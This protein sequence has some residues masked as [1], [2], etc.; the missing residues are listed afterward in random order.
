[1]YS[2]EWGQVLDNLIILFLF[3]GGALVTLCVIDWALSWTL[4]KPEELPHD[5]PWES[6]PPKWSSEFGWATMQWCPVCQVP[7]HLYGQCPVRIVQRPPYDWKKE[8]R[9]DYARPF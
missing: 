6:C 2:T 5:H 7:G 1:M 9:G 8:E 4:F 3:G